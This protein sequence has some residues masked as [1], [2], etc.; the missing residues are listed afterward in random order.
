MQW[1]RIGFRGRAAGPFQRVQ[2]LA[3]PLRSHPHEELATGGEP[4]VRAVLALAEA[5]DALDGKIES[6][7]GDAPFDRVGDAL[8]APGGAACLIGAEAPVD[9]DEQLGRRSVGHG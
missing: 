6:A 2:N 5:A 3:N 4:H 8:A 9:A 7:F 1:N